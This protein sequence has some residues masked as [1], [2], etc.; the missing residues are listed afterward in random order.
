MYVLHVDCATCMLTLLS[1]FL[2]LCVAV[3]PSLADFTQFSSNGTSCNIIGNTDV[4]G[5]GIRLGLYLQ[6]F[7]VLMA[8][9]LA[10]AQMTS[11]RIASNIINLAVLI[12]T[13]H[14]A[15]EGSL[16]SV[17]WYIVTW[18]TFVLNVGNIPMNRLQIRQAAGSFSTM[19]L[20]WS[21]IL[22]AQPWLYFEGV[23]KGR[24]EGCGADIFFFAPLSVYGAW[25]TVG[26][27]F[28]IIGC[29][30]GLGVL[31]AVVNVFLIGIEPLESE[32]DIPVDKK[33]IGWGSFFLFLW[34]A[35]T[36]SI[37]IV[38]VEMTIRANH[39]DMSDSRLI[40]SGQLIPF[41]VGILMNVV[42]IASCLQARGWRHAPWWKGGNQ[43]P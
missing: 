25:N 32:E 27:V 43:P 38:Q 7:G 6:W 19:L 37:S 29:V 16:V 4:Y 35:I 10:P 39:I 41:M 36:G 22:F 33:E 31:I 21:I 30:C 3:R 5:I 8:T 24:K 12:N 11:G 14:N 2:V 23:D 17:E 15:S 1:R 28:G 26:K 18:M 20:L 34:Q 9:F 40:D 42:V 13:F